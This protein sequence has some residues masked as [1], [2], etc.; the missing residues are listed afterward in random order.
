QTYL[1]V[2]VERRE[3][4]EAALGAPLPLPI[5]AALSQ[6]M[7]AQTRRLVREGMSVE[8]GG[9]LS[10]ARFL[11]PTMRHAGGAYR[12][13][14][15]ALGPVRAERFLIAVRKACDSAGWR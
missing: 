4:L 12:M 15:R 2:Q 14:G 3:M 5:L 1:K 6:N 11:D 13:L 7:W 10:A 9:Y 8:V